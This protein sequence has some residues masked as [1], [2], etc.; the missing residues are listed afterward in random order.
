MS[1]EEYLN[2]SFQASL[3]LFG[4]N[5]PECEEPIYET[6]IIT[7]EE[8]EQ[9]ERLKEIP[10][11]EKY[12]FCYDC[13]IK[14]CRKNN[15]F[16]IC[17]ECGK[18]ERDEIINPAI[19]P[20]IVSFPADSNS[21]RIKGVTRESRNQNNRLMG[22]SDP[23]DTKRKKILAML[24]ARV[25]NPNTSNT[26]PL[27]ILQETADN[28][29]KLQTEECLVKRAGGLESILSSL[30]HSSCLKHNIPRKAKD[31][32]A[33]MGISSNRISAG[34][35]LLKEYAKK[36][37]IEIQNGH[38]RT[39]DY[40]DQYFEKLKIVDA[41]EYKDFILDLIE[42]STLEKITIAT[43][44]TRP[45]TRIAGSLYIMCVHLK[46]G[47]SSDDVARECAISKSTIMRFIRLINDYRNT[48]E[49]NNIFNNYFPGCSTAPITK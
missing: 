28:Y 2:S 49:I 26:L 33:I 31:I 3:D 16:L 15:L 39:I 41:D 4:I 45:T 29:Y 1:L 10:K 21:L 14:M 37:I 40:I 47:I 36:G 48:E 42:A 9:E 7:Q 8:L 25:F 5:I 24:E 12:M 6:K 19:Q 20:N 18:E 11:D 17:L 34:N 35:K 30:I 43:N 38:G 13:D 22:S 32:A 44:N 23:K 27:F 46:N